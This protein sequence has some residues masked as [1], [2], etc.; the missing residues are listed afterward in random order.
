MTTP[1]L[2]GDLELTQPIS[3]VELPPRDDGMQY[4]GVRLLVRMQGM[5]VGYV[6]ILPD[7]V[8]A[9]SVARAAWQQLSSS[10]NQRRSQHGLSPITKLPLAGMPAETELAEEVNGRP[11]I[12]IVLCT[13]DRPESLIVT[14]RG[15]ATLRYTPFE[16]VVVDNAPSTDMTR[17][18]FEA[19]FGNDPRF[20][21]VCEP[22][23]GS[24]CAKN[25][26]IAEST[27]DIVAFTDDDVRVDQWWLDG[28]VR[29]FE[30]ADDV[31][32]VTGLVRTAVLD[33]VAQLY[34]DV[35]QD[36]GSSCERRIFDLVEH[37]HDSPLYP[38]SNVFGAGANFAMKRT[39]LEQ[40][41]GFDEALGA[42]TLCGGGEDL[43][44]FVRTVLAG[45]RL[46]YEPSAIVS[47]VH[48]A[49][50]SDLEKQMGTYGSGATAA[51]TALV[52]RNR[53]ARYE[54]LSKLI[55]GAV[56][57]LAIGKRT[58]DQPTLP[59]GLVGKEL[60]GMTR[61]PWLYLKARHKL[62]RSEYRLAESSVEDQHGV[63]TSSWRRSDP[64]K[65]HI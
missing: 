61:G 60:R 38:Y 1:I 35:R 57:I 46:V 13:R 2:V 22:R 53:R 31:A 39:A 42:G 62:R 45:H 58:K 14:L 33:T 27:A 37:R 59:S 15:I 54:L 28:I 6:S 56:R 51:L 30:Q 52:L 44:V 41:G 43:D 24:S 5:P 47:H 49:E 23:P 9:T 7:E 19:E 18:A 8:D 48:R 29:G 4:G 36:W 65:G 25:R 12:S 40:L 11:A 17:A 64:G 21:Y 3:D 26:G 20:R 32:C 63:R 34:F 55:I 50:L 10:I 16:I